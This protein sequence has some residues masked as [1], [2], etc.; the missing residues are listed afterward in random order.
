MPTGPQLCIVA[1]S[2]IYPEQHV[3]QVMTPYHQDS[4]EHSPVPGK[5]FENKHAQKSCLKINLDNAM[6]LFIWKVN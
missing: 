4:E 2:P 6:N 3:Y 5:K 1:E